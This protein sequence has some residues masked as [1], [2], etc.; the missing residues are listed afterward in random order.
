MTPRLPQL[1][2]RTLSGNILD[3]SIGILHDSMLDG[4][5][6]ASEMLDSEHAHLQIIGKEVSISQ[7]ESETVG[8]EFP[9]AVEQRYAPSEGSDDER[10]GSVIGGK[11]KAKEVAVCSPEKFSSSDETPGI[12]MEV[13]CVG[14]LDS[15]LSVLTLPTSSGLDA[16]VASHNGLVNGLDPS[17]TQLPPPGKMAGGLGGLGTGGPGAG[18]LGTGGLGA[19]GLG[20]A[21]GSDVGGPGSEGLGPAGGLE[22]RSS[23]TE[24][25]IQL[26]IL[27]LF[28]DARY[29]LRFPVRRYSNQASR[30]KKKLS[31]PLPVMGTSSKKRGRSRKNPAPFPPSGL[32]TPPSLIRKR[33]RPRKQVPQET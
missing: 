9:S 32:E 15:S 18:G 2:N 28:Q 14:G 5:G 23:E 11:R 16:A 30:D 29:D 8:V 24:G 4:N 7:E 21:G 6:I 25:E 1:Q 17:P 19:G 33:G 26:T 10:N 31:P 20:P 3:Q 13:V 22:V 27:R 12:G